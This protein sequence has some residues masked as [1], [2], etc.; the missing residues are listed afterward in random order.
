MRRQL[1]LLMLK[2]LMNLS[3]QDGVVFLGQKSLA[4]G[5]LRRGRMAS[6]NYVR[7]ERIDALSQVH[8]HGWYGE[9]SGEDDRVPR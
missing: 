5:I 7:H 3:N 9:G 1:G 4:A 2:M 8:L 6:G